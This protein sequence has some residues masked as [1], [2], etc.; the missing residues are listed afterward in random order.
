MTIQVR[1]LLVMPIE[2]FPVL[3]GEKVLHS[4]SGHLTHEGF[5][6][7]SR[8]AFTM[9]AVGCAGLIISTLGADDGATSRHN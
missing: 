3:Y 8:G 9:K 5:R 4:D 1:S 6:I 7:D 2:E